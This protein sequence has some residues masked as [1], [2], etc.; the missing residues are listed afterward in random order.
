[1][2]DTWRV[3]SALTIDYGLRWDRQAYGYEEHDR[4]SMFSPDMPIRRQAAC[5][6]PQFTRETAL[7]PAT[8][9]S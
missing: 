8:A 5:S 3:K 4:R 7:G 1:M 2:Q 9:G 6:A